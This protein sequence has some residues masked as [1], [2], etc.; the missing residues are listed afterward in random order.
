MEQKL[1]FR[2]LILLVSLN[3]LLL[4][5]FLL[6]WLSFFV[7]VFFGIS[8]ILGGIFLLFTHLTSFRVN[9]V[10]IALY[11]NS[12]VLFSYSFFFIGAGGLLLVLMALGIPY[13][14]TLFKKYY[15]WNL[16]FVRRG[17]NEIE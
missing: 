9:L 16:I 10:P 2:N 13:F 12:L 6:L 3:A 11:D 14:L 4:I 1:N 15:H 7:L 17:H 5:P 8:G